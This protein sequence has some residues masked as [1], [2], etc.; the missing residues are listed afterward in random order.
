MRDG[1]CETAL[2]LIEVM[3][4]VGIVAILA[5]VFVPWVNGSLN[6]SRTRRYARSLQ[7][8]FIATQSKAMAINRCL[9][10][11]FSI[12]SGS[13]VR[14]SRYSK[15]S[16]ESDG[17]TWT[18]VRGLAG[19]RLPDTVEIHSAGSSLGRSD[20]AG[21]ACVYFGRDGDISP[22]YDCSGGNRDDDNWRGRFYVHLGP[23][24][25]EFPDADTCRFSTLYTEWLTQVNQPERVDF[26]AFDEFS[27][28]PG[29]DPGC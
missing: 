6:R 16:C 18:R 26:G 25:V 1:C 8:T 27:E 4:V 10:V 29:E 5:Q 15:R 23:A 12:E 13:A 9:K 28:K 7:Q 3:V 2:T 20:D 21:Q 14:V 11:R 24:A 19:Y 17:G 22:V